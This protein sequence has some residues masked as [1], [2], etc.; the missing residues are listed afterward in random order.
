MGDFEPRL[1]YN[2]ILH[3]DWMLAVPRTQREVLG[4]DIN[5]LGFAGFLLARSEAVSMGLAKG[6]GG[7]DLSPLRLLRA[8][9]PQ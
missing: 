2:L 7:G 5:G 6:A 3:P 1:A 4:V 8:V 9:V